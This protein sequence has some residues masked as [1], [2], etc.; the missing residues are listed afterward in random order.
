MET[1]NMDFERQLNNILKQ[2]GYLFPDTDSQ[3][4]VFEKNLENVPLP[5]EFE[6]PD[7]VF[8]EKRK[9]QKP[10]V[11]SIDNSEA[12]TNWAIAARDGKEITDDIWAK[13]KLDKENARKEQNGNK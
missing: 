8:T 11:I 9:Q 3:M 10:K 12:E 6:T 1:E 2:Y 4:T 5:K 7:F 13:M